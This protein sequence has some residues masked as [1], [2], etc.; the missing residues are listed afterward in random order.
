MKTQLN[1]AFLVI[2]T[3]KIVGWMLIC[4]QQ[5]VSDYLQYFLLCVVDP[6]FGSRCSGSQLSG[7]GGLNRKGCSAT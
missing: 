7:N 2:W 3:V 5:M 4:S 6:S 1:I